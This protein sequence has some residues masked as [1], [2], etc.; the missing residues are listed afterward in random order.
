MTAGLLESNFRI[1]EAPQAGKAINP[2]RAGF[3]GL[4][5]LAGL[6]MGA[7]TLFGMGRR[8]RRLLAA[9]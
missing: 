7:M 9:R 6:I 8:Q 1:L 3:A 2:N 5:A 4:G